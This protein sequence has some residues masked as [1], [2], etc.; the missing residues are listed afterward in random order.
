MTIGASQ[1]NRGYVMASPRTAVTVAI[2]LPPNF[3]LTDYNAI[4]QRVAPLQPRLPEPFKQYAGAWNA[5]A[6]RYRAAAEAL[7]ALRA[8][9]AATDPEGRYAQELGLFGFFANSVA[10]LDGLAYGVHAI[11]AM[12]AQASFPLDAKA[13]RAI[14]LATVARTYVETFRDERL[15]S[16]LASIASD[17]VFVELSEIRNALSH[18]SAS[19]RKITLA[20]G[21][22]PSAPDCWVLDYLQLRNG[23]ESVEI[24]DAAMARYVDWLS[25]QLGAAFADTFLFVSAR[26]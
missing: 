10:A 15:G 14:T 23:L 11:G 21:N 4:H 12:A 13:L 19:N 2:E 5:V 9:L 8:A 25:G 3:P 22:V 17:A 6:Y 26:F 18:R 1:A 16:T 20:T 24:S 7:G